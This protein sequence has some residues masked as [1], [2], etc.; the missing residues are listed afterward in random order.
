MSIIRH[1][2]YNG[3][4]ID[5]QNSGILHSQ[6]LLHNFI[7]QHQPRY[8]LHCGCP[9]NALSLAYFAK[10]NHPC[11][12]LHIK[13]WV[14]LAQHWREVTGEIPNPHKLF[15]D[16]IADN[17]LDDYL[18]SFNGSAETALEV[19]QSRH[20][21]FNMMVSDAINNDMDY[22]HLLPLLS[23][24]PL[25]IRYIGDKKISQIKEDFLFQSDIET[26]FA[27][28]Q[29]YLITGMDYL[30]LYEEQQPMGLLKNSEQMDN[31]PES[32]SLQNDFV[33]QTDTDIDTDTDTSEPIWTENGFVYQQKDTTHRLE[34]LSPKEERELR[35]Q[36]RRQAREERHKERLLYNETN[37]DTPTQSHQQK[38]V[39]HTQNTTATDD[40]SN[41]PRFQIDDN[42]DN[43]ISAARR[44]LRARRAARRTNATND[45][46]ES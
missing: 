2:L 19:L 18:V 7:L 38:T 6:T 30:S 8:I 26:S 23:K 35:R 20:F 16:K 27:Y 34:Q 33:N 5:A 36:E 9:D 40:T 12:I 10:E 43:T 45:V 32:R 21:H 29:G 46:S 42:G 1:L 44:A 28:A 14:P 37:N 39:N 15:L 24:K 11:E 17:K 25:H 13:N 3:A 41:A 31:A 4:S 22:T